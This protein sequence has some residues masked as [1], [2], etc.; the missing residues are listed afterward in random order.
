MD[1]QRLRILRELGELGSARAVAEA[2]HITPSAVSQQLRLLQRSVPVPLTQRVGRTLALTDAGRELASAAIEIE[3]ARAHAR[4]VAAQLSRE[5]A[6]TV[7]VSAFSSAALTF[8]GPLA[9]TFGPESKVHVELTDEDVAQDRFPAL[10]ATYDIVVAHRLEHTPAWPSSVRTVP[11]LREPQDVALPANHPLATGQ[12]LTPTDVAG[13]TWIATHAGFPP[14]A[15]LDAIA[16]VAGRPIRIAH[17]VNEFT[18]AAEL[19]RAGAGLALIPRW[20]TPAPE[21]VVLRPLAGVVSARRIDA[22]LRPEKATRPATRTVTD[23]LRDLAREISR[24][25]PPSPSR[26]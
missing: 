4:D 22:L 8:F 13:E 3:R 25:V 26:A 6:G 19:V 20:T 24:K 11:L 1:D 7:T 9:E 18:V 5:P 10:T 2:L 14:G 23:R 17:R 12:A 16:A 21:G 15:I